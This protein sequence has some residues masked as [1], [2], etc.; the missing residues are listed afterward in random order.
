MKMENLMIL[1]DVIIRSDS[2]MGIIFSYIY[3]FIIGSFIGWISEVLFRRFFSM[4]KWI[5]PGFMKGPTLPLYGFGLCLLYTVCNL[6]FIY[7]CNG[8]GIPSF[9]YVDP[10]FNFSGPF[11]F[12]ITTLIIVIIVGISMTVLEFLAG[13]IFVKGF[14]IKLWDYSNLK[15]NIMGIICPLFSFIWLIAGLF[16]WLFIHSYIIVAMNFFTEHIWGITFVLGAYVSL[17]IFDLIQSIKLGAKVSGIAKESKLLVD[18]EKF[19]SNIRFDD[20]K[21]K[22]DKTHF[23]SNVEKAASKFRNKL[24]DFTY[25]IKRHMYV[26]NKLPTVTAAQIDETPRMKAKR[27]EEENKNKK[28]E[29]K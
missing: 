3:L 16:Y 27:L 24:G 26:N 4:K 22:N 12:W 28:T 10:A 29:K 6:S 8:K 20:K 14:R 11:S 19:K 23:F 25:D 5:N 13:I 2:I 7:L 18:F 9:F 15:G 21:R 1:S 17:F